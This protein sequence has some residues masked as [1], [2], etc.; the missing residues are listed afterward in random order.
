M[1]S[2]PLT[3]RQF[4]SRSFLA[5]TASA[6]TFSLTGCNAFAD[7]LA[8]TAVASTA[9]DG[10][11]TVLGSLLPPGGA[12]IV[13]LIKA[14]LADLAAAIT[15]YNSDT[16]PANK[17]TLLAKIRTFLEAIAANLQSFFQ[18]ITSAGPAVNIALGL[19]Q[20]IL[21][22]VEGFI[23]TLPPAPTPTPATLQLHAGSGRTVPVTPKVYKHV[24]D[25]KRDWNTLA[26]ADGHPEI[27]IH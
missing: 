6:F 1:F 22:A 25:F 11:V 8:W 7:I 24:G 4:A 3:R 26:V 20:V 12:A 18:Q 17:A 2:Q 27:Q 23:G 5:A 9:V 10:I 15:Q 16:N 19:A 21:A 13:T 14:A